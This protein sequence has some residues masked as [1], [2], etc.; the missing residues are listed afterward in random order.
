MVWHYIIFTGEVCEIS[1]APSF[2]FMSYESPI[3]WLKTEHLITSHSLLVVVHMVLT[4]L[5][6]GM[7]DLNISGPIPNIL[8]LL[9][10]IFFRADP[11]KSVSV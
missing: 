1:L 8:K 10:F 7:A 4:V 11:V 2:L 5:G 9:L 6:N 3:V